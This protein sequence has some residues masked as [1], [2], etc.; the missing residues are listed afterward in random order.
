MP[1]DGAASRATKLVGPSSRPEPVMVPTV[2]SPI[3]LVQF[4]VVNKLLIV[5]P[6]GRQRSSAETLK[7]V[8]DCFMGKTM[9]NSPRPKV[10]SR[11]CLATCLIGIL[12]CLQISLIQ[13]PASKLGANDKPRRLRTNLAFDVGTRLFAESV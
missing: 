5:P 8:P 11:R 9:A 3:G 2:Q 6:I 12:L 7:V 10:S 13:P 4:C 1:A